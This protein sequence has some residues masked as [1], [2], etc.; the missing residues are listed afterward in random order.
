MLDERAGDTL[1]QDRLAAPFEPTG[2]WG[3]RRRRHV[4]RPVPSAQRV[5]SHIGP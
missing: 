2:T 3:G 5:R 4:T 1:R